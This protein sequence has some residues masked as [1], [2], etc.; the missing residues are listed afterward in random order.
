MRM[1]G[2]IVSARRS[3]Q[4]SRSKILAKS[5]LHILA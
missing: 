2:L 5:K 1:R 3:I 4:T